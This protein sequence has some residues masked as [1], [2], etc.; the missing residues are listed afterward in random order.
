TGSKAPRP[1]VAIGAALLTFG[2]VL[3]IVGSF[4]SWFEIDGETFNGFSEGG[5]NGDGTKDGPVFAVLGVLALS[6]G[7]VQLAARKVLALGIIGIVVGAFGLL[8]A[9]A[10]L[11][12][13]ND[14]VD[15][16]EAFGADVSAGPGLYVVILGAAVAIAGAIA[17]IAKRRIWTP[18]T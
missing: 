4:L 10:D 13:V 18:T 14:L 7:L 17:T 9:I 5:E 3:M 11:S 15:L 6:F 8:A 12:D 16:G 1:A 2:G